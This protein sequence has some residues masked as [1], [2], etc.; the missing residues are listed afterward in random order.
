MH[1]EV[2]M[3]VKLNNTLSLRRTAGY[4]LS[5][6]RTIISVTASNASAN[7]AAELHIQHSFGSI[8][9][10]TWNDVYILTI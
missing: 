10:K 3:I 2:R 9:I 7:T 8:L 1:T 6:P 5:A 4:L